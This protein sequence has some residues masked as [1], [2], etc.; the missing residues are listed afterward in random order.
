MIKNCFSKKIHLVKTN[1]Q[2]EEQ[3]TLSS[4][5]ELSYELGA[6]GTFLPITRT[7]KRLLP[8]KTDK[9]SPIQAILDISSRQEHP[10]T[11]I[12]SNNQNGSA[13]T[14]VKEIS[15]INPINQKEEQLRPPT[16]PLQ[17]LAS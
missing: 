10:N 6:S 15:T 7:P 16:I 12:T 9:T 1:H 17:R 8:A 14:E 13:T 4:G 11:Q 3:Q 5:S 2:K